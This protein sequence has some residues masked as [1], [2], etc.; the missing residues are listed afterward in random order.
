VHHKVLKY[1]LHS[2][3][4][5]T[6]VNQDIIYFHNSRE[7]NNNV[8]DLLRDFTTLGHVTAQIMARLGIEPRPP[9][10]IPGALPI[11]LQWAPKVLQCF[12]VSDCLQCGALWH[13]NHT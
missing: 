2:L 5:N 1:V 8:V 10:Y 11:E 6:S 12:A 9:E 7:S 4:Q 13:G 3:W